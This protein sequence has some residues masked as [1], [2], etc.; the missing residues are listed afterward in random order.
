MTKKEFVESMSELTDEDIIEIRSESGMEWSIKK[1]EKKED[2][3][4]KKF[5][6]RIT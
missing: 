2:K 4:G 5:V 3:K 1:W 6:M